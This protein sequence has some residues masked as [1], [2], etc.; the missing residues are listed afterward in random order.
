MIGTETLRALIV[1]DQS[2]MRSIVRKMLLQ[3]PEFESIEDANEAPQA[4]TLIDA[5]ENIRQKD[6]RVDSR[7][8]IMYTLKV[9]A[10]KG[11]SKC[12]EQLFRIIAECH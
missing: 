4:W 11:G 5:T 3:I 10:Y 12:Q 9:Y 2:Q 1:E 7:H 8:K 6:T